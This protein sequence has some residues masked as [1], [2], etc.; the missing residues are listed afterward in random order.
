MTREQR[1][2]AIAYLLE[3]GATC[4]QV[5]TA[6]IRILTAASVVLGV[7][8]IAGNDRASHAGTDRLVIDSLVSPNLPSLFW[9]Q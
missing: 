3:R 6:I 1:I 8:A 5:A 7:A 2:D 4:P 9:S